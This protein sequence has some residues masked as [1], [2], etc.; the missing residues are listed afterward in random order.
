[1]S[2]VDVS[3][4]DIATEVLEL[5]GGK[6]NV[7][8][9]SLCM[10]RL[11]LRLANIDKVDNAALNTMPGVLGLATRGADG[12]EVVFGPRLVHDVYNSF[13]AL[14]GLDPAEA[15]VVRGTSPMSS[16]LHV[17]IGAA[18]GKSGSSPQQD[19][20]SSETTTAEDLAGLEALMDDALPSDLPASEAPAPDNPAYRLLVINGPNINMV[21]IREP[22]TYGP[23]GY[24]ELLALCHST[25]NEVGFAECLCYQSNHEGDIVDR[26]QDAYCVFDGIIINPG[27]YTHTSIA[28]LDALKAVCIPAIEVHISKVSERE[29]FRQISYVRQACF[30]T[31][32]GEGIDG[33][34]RA[35]IDMA[36]HLGMC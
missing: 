33:Y 12:I 9:N 25:A 8:S 26:I 3:S 16:S 31:I 18:Q 2:P 10:T 14:T 34:R 6:D 22:D 13:V 5:V 4:H 19:A 24:D 11:R 27:A 28:I 21:G 20:T 36:H 15:D 7:L 35:I 32:Q 29:E 30:E 23:R 17:Q 1:M